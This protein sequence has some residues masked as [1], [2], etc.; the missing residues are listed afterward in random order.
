[1]TSKKSNQSEKQAKMVPR[2]PG[3]LEH[4]EDDENDPSAEVVWTP[5]V[6]LE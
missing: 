1:M 4:Q 2:E 6:D 5:A 3:K